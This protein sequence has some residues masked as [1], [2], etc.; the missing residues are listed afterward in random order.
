LES[1][2]LN[3]AFTKGQGAYLYLENDDGNEIRVLDLVG[4]FG[5]GLLGHNNRELKDL[6]K[7]QLDAD[8]PFLAQSSDRREAGR[9][10]EKLNLILPTQQKYL[11]HLTN[12]GAEAVEAA[13]KHAYK[14]RFDSL[15][16]QFDS[17]A[18]EIEQ[19]YQNTERDHPDIEIPGQGRDLGKFRDDL[20]EHNLAQFELFQKSPVVLAFKGSFHGKTTSALKVTFNKTYREGFEGLSALRPEFIDFAD[21]ERLDEIQRAFQVEF[22]VPRVEDGRIVVENLSAS[23]IVALCLEIIQ[24]EGGIRPVPEE[25]LQELAAQHDRL[26]LPYLIDE[27]QTGCGRTG[28]F[29]AYGAGPLREIDPEY[30]PLQ[31]TNW[32]A[33]SLAKWWTYSRATTTDT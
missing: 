27:I 26:G 24:G 22:L 4:G 8:V 14:V 21:V 28:S 2:G 12:S 7:S 9:L 5:A 29:V 23:R 3:V 25:V 10:A 13:L 32:H 30:P 6:L 33:L 11:C 20:D 17:I 15:R 16:R 31:K 18:R 19:F 1:L